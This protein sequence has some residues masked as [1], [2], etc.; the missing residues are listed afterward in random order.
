MTKKKANVPMKIKF[1]GKIYGR[2]ALARH[3]GCDPTTVRDWL[4]A[5]TD[6]EMAGRR[7]ISKSLTPRSPATKVRRSKL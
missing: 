6:I 7:Y 1:M 2:N 5:G 3:L 4:K